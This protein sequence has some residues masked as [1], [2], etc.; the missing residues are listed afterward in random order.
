[1]G[2]LIVFITIFSGIVAI[3]TVITIVVLINNRRKRVTKEHP[4]DEEAQLSI[5]EQYRQIY[6]DR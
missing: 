4:S 3:G 6:G 5:E 2:V 1:M